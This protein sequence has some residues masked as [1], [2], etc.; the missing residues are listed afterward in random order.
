[1]PEKIAHALPQGVFTQ[2]RD[3]GWLQF[4]HW[5]SCRLVIC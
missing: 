1:L 4:S 5:L 3:R 2:G